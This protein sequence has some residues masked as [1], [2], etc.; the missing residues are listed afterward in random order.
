MK[1]VD[2]TL[3]DAFMK[4]IN[5]T[6]EENSQEQNESEVVL[7]AKQLKYKKRQ[8]K[9][10]LKAAK[11]KEKEEMKAEKRRKKAEEQKNKKEGQV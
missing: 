10:E 3:E 9:K 4:L 2:A 6:P 8:E 5:S 7:D 11:R 1:K